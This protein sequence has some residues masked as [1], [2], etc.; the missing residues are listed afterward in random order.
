MKIQVP[1]G[2]QDILPGEVEKW[3]YVEAMM[4]KVASQYGFQEIRTPLFEHTELFQRGIGMTTD[5]VEK[6]MYTFED[7]GKRSLTL[8][9]EGTA[10]AA[11]AFIEHSYAARPQP[12]KFY[13]IGPSFR[14]ERPQAGRYRQHH[15][16][17]VE[18]FGSPLPIAD[19]EVIILALDLF[20]RLGLTELTVKLNNIGC[21]ICRQSYRQ[22][23]IDYLTPRADNL[24]ADCRNRLTRNPLRVLDCKQDGCGAI[25]AN[26]PSI[27][28]HLC[29]DCRDHFSRVLDYLR[30]AAVRYEVDP[31]I[32]RGLDYYTRTVFEIVYSGLG[33]QSTVCG[34][35]RYDNL[36]ETVGGPATPGVGFGMGIERLLLTLEK[37]G[38][39]L[40][41]ERGPDLYIAAIG[42]AAL[43]QAFAAMY[44]LRQA[45]V[46]VV[47]DLMGRSLKAQ[48]KYADKIGARYVA[49]LGEAELAAGQVQLKQMQGGEDWVIAWSDLADWLTE[50]LGLEANKEEVR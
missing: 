9:P 11:R 12:T 32:V 49:V 5:V 19:A 16:F 41:G 26:A 43:E 36:I 46:H 1:K 4:R 20:S 23:L 28:D 8:R 10:G 25:V 45:G 30:A 7:K 13:Y 39:Y 48:L 34:G 15:Q 17:G 38:C 2:T 42:D 27:T 14:Y 22:V 24:C 6:E 44:G 37:N 21:P 3:H 18:V 40:P 33:A 47:T 35:G 29:Q 31:K 50:K